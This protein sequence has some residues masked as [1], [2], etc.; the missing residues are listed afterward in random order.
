[1]GT[2]NITEDLTAL[3]DDIR[4]FYRE[5]IKEF[6]LN[7]SGQKEDLEISSIYERYGHLFS[8]ALAKNLKDRWESSSGDEE[9]RSYKHLFKFAFNGFIGEKCKKLVEELM[10]VQSEMKITANG[11]EI[12]YHSIFPSLINEADKDRRTEIDNAWAECEV[13]LDK[14][15][16]ELWELTYGYFRDFG[17]E[18]YRE[19]CRQLSGVDFDWLKAE[20]I[21][22]IDESEGEYGR[23][24]S[25]LSE[26]KLG[27]PLK[28]ARKCD[29]SYLLKAQKWDE[30]FPGDGMVENSSKF[31]N[32][33][34]IPIANV[35]SINLDIEER[36]KKRPRAFCSPVEAGKEVYVVLRPMGGSN[37][38]LTFLHELG[39]AYH[40]AHVD[41]TYPSEFILVGDS[42]T[43]EIFAFNFNYLGVEPKWLKKYLNM[44]NP[45]GFVEHQ[46]LVKLYFI[47]RYASKFLYELELHS[48]YEMEPRQHLYAKF[49]DQ[50][51]IAKHRKEHWLYDLDDAY[52]SAGYLRAWIF[53]VQLR[54][55]LREKY[56]E[57][58]WE[59]PDASELLKKMWATGRK[60]MP[61][62]LSEMMLG[63]PL[64]LEPIKRE[65]LPE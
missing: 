25:A 10:K 29:L 47:R 49:L 14:W 18:S 3:R 39:H 16:R 17:Y 9:K 24:V 37:D 44:E 60:Y 1:M 20:L 22:F 51:L 58:W 64:S 38:Y 34:N 62:E 32:S 48:D 56:G 41:Q 5:L 43:S 6:Y 26:E 36:E 50:G 19:G 53:E 7:S 61:E 27:Y 65:L 52:Y 57:E 46:R 11:E 40:F 13:K 59:S 28:D 15:R 63:E 31:L 42:A 8:E 2:I 23:I 4:K 33:M 45:E 21:S 55:H 35:D 12:G 54:E 30:Y